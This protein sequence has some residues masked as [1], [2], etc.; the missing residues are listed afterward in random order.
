MKHLIP[1]IPFIAE[2]TLD[3]WYIVRLKK[4]DIFDLGHRTLAVITCALLVVFFGNEAILFYKWKIML[5]SL[6]LGTIPFMY[7]DNI[8]AW[9]RGK[10]G[11]DYQGKSKKYDLW[12]AR[13]NPYSL[14]IVRTVIAA[15]L[16]WAFIKLL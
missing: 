8:L 6:I 2:L 4:Q 9:L 14:L 16:F 11:L 3:H 7:F 10:R 15:L 13:V 5:R 1:L 12:L